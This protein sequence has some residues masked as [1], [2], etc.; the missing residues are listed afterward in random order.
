MEIFHSTFCDDKPQT[1]LPTP[2]EIREI[3]KKTGIGHISFYR[4]PPVKIPSL[5]LF[6]KYGADVTV[7]EA[8]TQMMLHEHL[9]DQAPI[10]KVFGGAEDGGQVFIYM[11]LVEGETLQE[12][13]GGMNEPERLSVCEEL[14]HMVKTWR[15]LEQDSHSRYI[16]SLGG[17]PLNEIF[18]SSH[19][20]ISGPFQGA[21]AVQQFQDACGI[22]ISED[23]PIVFT[24]DDLV[25]PNILLSP[26]PNPR[27]VAVID[28]GQAGW[29]P[30]YWEYCKARR[31]RLD[32]ELFDDAIQ[33]QWRTK[34]LPMI[35]HPVDEEAIYRPWLY[36]VLSKGI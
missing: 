36:F 6:V 23:V 8:Q 1:T 28:W 25:P 7:V 27:V 18:L 30:A 26:G 31:V 5:G 10:P 29:Y 22:E 2:S 33:E 14:K 4:P 21:N 34:Y 32:P 19:P 35:L 17:L 13:W 16:G 12:R 20:E 11:S 3:S 9:K 24:H 15:T